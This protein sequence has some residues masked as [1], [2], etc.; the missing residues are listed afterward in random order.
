MTN[1]VVIFLPTEDCV[2][3]G[4]ALVSS[5]YG[6]QGLPLEWAGLRL[7]GSMLTALR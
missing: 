1:K 3:S 7:P 6:P 4:V 2:M 5:T